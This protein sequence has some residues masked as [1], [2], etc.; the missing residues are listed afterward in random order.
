MAKYIEK[1]NYVNEVRSIF[2]RLRQNTP[3]LA[4]GMNGGAN[5]AEAR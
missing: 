1:W 3:W 4:T 5:L 2:I